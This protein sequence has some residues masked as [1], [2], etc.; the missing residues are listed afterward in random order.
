MT[1]DRV[2][3]ELIALQTAFDQ[4]V[5]RRCVDNWGINGHVRAA[6]GRGGFSGMVS[7]DPTSELTVRQLSYSN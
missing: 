6:A 2:P 7:Y 4:V 1:D 5:Y 3:G